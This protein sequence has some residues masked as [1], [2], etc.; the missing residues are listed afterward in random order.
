MALKIPEENLQSIAKILRLPEGAI[1]EVMNA[2]ESTTITAEPSAMAE[3]IAEMVPSIP[4]EDLAAVVQTLYSL[5][6]V[7]EFSGVRPARFVR[8]LVDT[9]LQNPAIGAEKA[10]ASFV[11]KRF[12]RLLNAKTLNVLSKAVRIQR[13][14]GP[15]FYDAKIISDI[16]PVFGDDLAGGPISAV[17]TH[18]LKLAYYEGEEQRE[19]LIVL[20]QQDLMY[21]NE[22]IERAQQKEEALDGV[23]EKLGLPRLGV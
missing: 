21:L 19:F 12:Q 22:V 16:R 3:N 23:L 6:H 15:I 11:G 9:I 8:D 1:D 7:R 18:T 20:D 13:E 2:L 4:R 10:E 14:I 17:I 5:Y